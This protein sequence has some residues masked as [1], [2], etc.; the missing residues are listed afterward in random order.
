MSYMHA[1]SFDHPPT[2]HHNGSS[3]SPEEFGSC[4]KQSRSICPLVADCMHMFALFIHN[5]SKALKK[6]ASENY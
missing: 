3:V 4:T 6:E 5:P 2:E 1:S